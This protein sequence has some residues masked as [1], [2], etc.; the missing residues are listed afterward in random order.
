MVPH[1]LYIV[2]VTECFRNFEWVYMWAAWPSRPEPHG[3]ITVSPPPVEI[4][5]PLPADVHP[6]ITSRPELRS[7]EHQ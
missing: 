7:P 5:A 4:I 2:W 6:R 3:T 1:V